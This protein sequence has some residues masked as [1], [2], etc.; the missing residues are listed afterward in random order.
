MI[1]FGDFWKI[2][3]LRLL[4]ARAEGFACLTGWMRIAKKLAMSTIYVLQDGQKTGP[5]TTE[6]LEGKVEAGALSRED[7]F[8]IEGMEEWQPL[9][10]VME[11]EA[12]GEIAP[13]DGIG[14]RT[15]V[16]HE[17]ADSLVTAQAVHLPCGEEIPLAGITRA[18]V[19]HEAVA[20]FKPMAG[21]IVLGVLIIV[22]ALLEIPRSTTTHWVIWG[23]GLIALA[24][25]WLRLLVRA[26]RVPASLVIIE[27]QG[28]DERIVR[29]K[30]AAAEELCGAINEARAEVVAGQG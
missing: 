28:G 14:E 11:I 8:W 18:A 3:V 27:L 20:R 15:D 23:V 21:C 19:Q 10:S 16:R 1:P 7:L 4:P 22:L 2:F 29:T 25:W 13:A 24:V 26:L 9:A 6:E 17:G 30:A 12:S 5:F